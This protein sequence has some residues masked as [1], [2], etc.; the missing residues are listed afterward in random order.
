MKALLQE[1]LLHE[2]P[3]TASLGL[4]VQEASAS[5][6]R[7]HFPLE[8]NHNHKQTAFGGSLYSAAVLAGWSVAWCALQERG[9]KAQVVIVD[10]GER[11]LKAVT[12]DFTAECGVDQAQIDAALKM[13]ARKGK[14]KLELESVVLCQGEACL[15]F[16]G[17]YGL[18]KV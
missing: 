18:I 7:L 17:T 11:F 1:T 10:S 16:K 3:L 8:P 12:A 15:A 5:L 4:T 9:L 6:V 13:L 14:A 2:I